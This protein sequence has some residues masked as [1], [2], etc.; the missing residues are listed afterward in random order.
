MKT[1]YVLEASSI[2][3]RDFVGVFTNKEKIEKAK[4]DYKKR[5]YCSSFKVVPI[6]LDEISMFF[7]DSWNVD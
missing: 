1:V 7:C 4:I 3:H 2:S 6:Q 5:N